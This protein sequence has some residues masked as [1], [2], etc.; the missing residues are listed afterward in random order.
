MTSASDDSRRMLLL[1]AAAFVPMFHS[2]A[3]GRGSVEGR[4]L[5]ELP[6][7]EGISADA[8]G[9]EKIL[10]AISE[11]RQLAAEQLY[12]YLNAGGATQPLVDAARLLVF[13]KG[14]N[15]H[16]YKFSSAAFED[17]A[18]LSPGWRE[19]Y[20]ATSVFNLRGAGEPDNGLSERV[21]AALA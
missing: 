18:I 9:V 1:Q 11:N 6:A 15:S 13:F 19:R 10:H 3:R 16:D 8:G 20:L 4:K 14:T 12:G 2:A 7:A 17:Y 5:D 21:R